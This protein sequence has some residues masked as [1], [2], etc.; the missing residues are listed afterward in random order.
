MT[1]KPSPP[2]PMNP[3]PAGKPPCRI[4][5]GGEDARVRA[6]IAFYEG[7]VGDADVLLAAAEIDGIDGEVALL[8][9]RLREHGEA[10]KEDLRLLER[11]VASLVRAVAARHRMSPQR[12][13]ELT[14]AMT[15]TF[16]SLAEQILGPVDEV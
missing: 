10:H 9:T 3:A 7:C 8:R 13:R 2:A 5:A 15:A 11:S 16:A 6:S 1:E 12:A 4:F 14:D